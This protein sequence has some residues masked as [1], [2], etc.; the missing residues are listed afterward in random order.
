MRGW[1]AAGRTGTRRRAVPSRGWRTESWRFGAWLKNFTKTLPNL[2][3]EEKVAGQVV[4][5]EGWRYL[6]IIGD[7]L[8]LASTGFHRLPQATRR[9]GRVRVAR[10][11]KS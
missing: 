5:K 1:G 2:A 11:I 8:F 7:K 9:R 3:D 10:M 6:G 4:G